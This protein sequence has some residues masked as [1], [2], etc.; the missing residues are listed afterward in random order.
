M[1]SLIEVRVNPSSLITTLEF[2]QPDFR[3]LNELT[4]LLSSAYSDLHYRGNLFTLPWGEFKRNLVPIGQIC[5]SNNIKLN[6]DEVSEQL[7]KKYLS[8]RS[9]LKSRATQFEVPENLQ[10]LLS[11]IGFDRPLKDEQKRDVGR[12]LSL[13]HGANFSVPGA[14]KTATMLAVFALLKH[15]QQV[16]KLFV[17]APINAFI[18]WEDEIKSIFG[19]ALR[20][21]R[22]T[23]PLVNNISVA[24]ADN[25]DVL[26][27]NYEKM[28]KEMCPLADFFWSNFVHFVLDES[29]R[30]K[31]GSN[32]LSFAQ[33]M[34]LADIA[35]RRDILSGTPMPQSYTDLFPQL[36][37]LWPAENILSR[38]SRTDGDR[39]ID[40][41]NESLKGLYVRTTKNEL[42]LKK[43]EFLY[44]L[45]PM[46]PLQAEIYQLLKS[47][48]ARIMAGMDNANRNNFRRIGRS[49]TK[50]LQA[51]SNPILLGEKDEYTEDVLPLPE[52]TRIWELLE[53]FISFEK[54]KKLER[55][56][57]R[58]AELLEK[59][60]EAK[61]VIWSYFIRNIFL[62]ERLLA[63]YNP[64]IIYGGVP[65]KSDDD[66]NSRESR[67]RKF[68]FD[69][70]CRLLI[71]NPQACGEGISLHTVC[72]HA[73]Y[74]DRSFNAAHYLQSIDRIHRLGLDPCVDTT[75]EIMVSEDTIDDVVIRRLNEKILAMGQIL[76]DRYLQTLVY[77]PADILASQEDGID[78]K[79]FDEIKRHVNSHE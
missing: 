25:P 62:L 2:V 1:E 78:G 59:S 57:S 10:G 32:N 8:D 7:V 27:I 67:I 43:P 74:L 52:N 21:T 6:F 42:G 15:Y 63:A 48:A 26:L 34:K 12:L 68:H 22:I 16:S 13:K 5:R 71:A 49:V 72:H 46:G 30:I 28:R 23:N 39:Q 65:A 19:P 56:R 45:V 24:I 58:V 37:F 44:T 79:D 3:A 29:H 31:S 76:D 20:V 9:S 64:V 47:E 50:L 41:I 18:S 61:I 60:Q 40:E 75:I 14:G 53:E 54:P 36:D 51:A 4:L 17:I 38:V 77:D 66:E 73:I 55:L 35:V 69:K 70:T 11:E 33:I